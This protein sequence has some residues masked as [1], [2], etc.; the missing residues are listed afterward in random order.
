MRDVMIALFAFAPATVLSGGA[1]YLAAHGISG[2]GWFL[3]V[4]VCLGGSY[5]YTSKTSKAGE[6]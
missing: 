1:I 5:N 2:W 3:F 4:A 6:G